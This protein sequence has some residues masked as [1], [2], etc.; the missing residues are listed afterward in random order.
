MKYTV[1]VVIFPGGKICVGINTRLC[2]F[3]SKVLIFVTI[4]EGVYYA[5]LNLLRN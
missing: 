1:K 3:H 5:V 4:R 2:D